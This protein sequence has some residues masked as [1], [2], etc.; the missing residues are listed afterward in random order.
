MLSDYKDHP[1]VHGLARDGYTLL[2]F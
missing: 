1:S 2:T